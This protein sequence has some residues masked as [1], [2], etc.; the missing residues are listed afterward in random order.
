MTFGVVFVVL[1]AVAA[2]PSASPR[3]VLSVVKSTRG[4]ITVK[5]ENVSEQP[6][7]LE[8]RTYLTLP[9]GTAEGAQEPMYWAEVDAPRL[10][11][12]APARRPAGKK[13]GGGPVG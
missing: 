5:V 11:Q 10:P 12:P 3:V 13:R 1:S 7:A 6:V 4:A 2:S 8:A 9:R